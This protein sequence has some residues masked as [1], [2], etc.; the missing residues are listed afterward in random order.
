MIHHDHHHHLFIFLYLLLNLLVLLPRPLVVLLPLL[1]TLDPAAPHRL[2]R[3]KY[4]KYETS[5]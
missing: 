1:V 5:R 4:E 3:K 2:Q